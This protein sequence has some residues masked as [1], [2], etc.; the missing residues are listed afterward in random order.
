[1][2]KILGVIF[3][4]LLLSG[5]AYAEDINELNDSCVKKGT[6]LFDKKVKIFTQ[7]KE[8]KKK[9]YIMYFGCISSE[10]WYWKTAVENDFDIANEK[11]YSGCLKGA[12]GYGIKN[13]HLFSIGNKIV[14]GKD[15][16]LITKIEDKL[17]KK[18]GK[19]KKSG[20]AF[21]H[22]YLLWDNL[23]FTKKSPTT[24]EK[25]TFNKEKNV[26]DIVQRVKR[27]SNFKKKKTFRSFNFLA[28]FENDITV[29]LFVEYEKDKKD[30]KKAEKEALFF[31]HM[32]GQMPNFLK[33]YNDKIFIHND[34]GYDDGLG[35]WWVNYKEKAFHINVP[36]HKLKP[37]GNQQCN[38]S[39]SYH[40]HCAVV[41]A[42]ELAHVIQQL[43]GVISPSKWSKARK[44][45]KKNYVSEY[46]QTDSKEDFAESIIA[47]IAVRYKADRISKSDLE[48]FN[49][50][51]LNRFKFFDELN[52]NLHPL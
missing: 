51:A 8:N 38:T 1:M 23:I 52:F 14:Y 28:E 49:E 40:S 46:A 10:S 16:A 30:F 33:T 17:K 43:T 35:L 25:L 45:D 5:N 13:C 36:R 11:A 34:N 4:N 21:V 3:L 22:E 18:L 48:K 19:K 29:E 7:T 24:F 12:S 44:L 39:N 9:A 37:S 42:H 26:I 41:M 31:S 20:N 47:W 27:T 50:F 6:L 15:A 32:Y 2:K